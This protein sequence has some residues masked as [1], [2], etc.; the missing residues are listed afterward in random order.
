MRLTIED[1]E[2]GDLVDVFPRSNDDFDEFTGNICKINTADDTVVVVDEN[3]E[4]YTVH[5]KQIYLT[6]NYEDGEEESS[7]Y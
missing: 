1:Y 2:V 5:V 4:K 3:Q 6:Y 7:N